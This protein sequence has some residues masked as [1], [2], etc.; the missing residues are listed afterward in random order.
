LS[1][2]CGNRRFRP[3]DV[4]WCDTGVIPNATAVTDPVKAEEQQRLFGVLP[5]FF[6]AYDRDAAPLKARQKLQLTAKTWFDPSSFF[7][8]G[9]IAGVWQA[10][11]THKGF[12]Q[13]SQGYGKRYGTSFADNGTMLLLEKVAT[14]TLFKQDPRYFYK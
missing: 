6:T 7:I 11:N 2:V 10:Q 14:P 3:H 13:G 9:I 4:E 1:L 12:G 5:N 8:D